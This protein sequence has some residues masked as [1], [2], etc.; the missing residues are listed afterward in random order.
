MLYFRVQN[1]PTP[2][3]KNIVVH[4]LPC[5]LPHNDHMAQC[6]DVTG[7]VIPNFCQGASNTM[8]WMFHACMP[9]QIWTANHVLGHP[10]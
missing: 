3:A 1:S 9:Q 6:F 4:A 10:T 5:L 2:L 7:C 8:V